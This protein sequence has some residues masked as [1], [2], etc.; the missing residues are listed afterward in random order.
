MFLLTLYPVF[1]LKTVYTPVMAQV[2]RYDYKTMLECGRRGYQV[3]VRQPLR[4][5]VAKRKLRKQSPQPVY[6]GSVRCCDF[7]AP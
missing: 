2:S 6:L 7:A 4:F 5:C 3:S 1:D